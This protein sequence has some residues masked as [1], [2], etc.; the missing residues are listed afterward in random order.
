[1][2]SDPAQPESAHAAVTRQRCGP[3][4]RCRFGVATAVALLDAR[5]FRLFGVGNAHASFFLLHAENDGF[6]AAD[7]G[8]SAP[9]PK[10]V[11]RAGS[12]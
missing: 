2:L 9:L 4:Y 5:R 7:N 10:F 11:I 6:N 8:T 3:K 1:M 12:L